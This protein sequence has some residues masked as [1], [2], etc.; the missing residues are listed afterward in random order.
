M[1]SAESLFFLQAAKRNL[2]QAHGSLCL[3]FSI[4][5]M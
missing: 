2:G 3:S 5:V 1:T 4:S